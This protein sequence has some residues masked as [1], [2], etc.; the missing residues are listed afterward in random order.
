MKS[1]FG[2]NIQFSLFG[3]S[4]G[5][6]IGVHI[7]GLAPG[8]PLDL[9][10]LR[11][12]LD[13]RRP[14]GKI[15]TR[16]READEFEIVSGFFNGYTTG[17]PLCILIRNQSQHSRDYDAVKYT[18]RPSH[19]DFTAFEK[20][21]GF[22]DYRGGGHFSGRITAPIV[23]AGAICLQILRRKGI[24]IA[25]HIAHCR[26]VADEPFAGTEQELQ[27]QAEVLQG[28]Y[29][30]VLCDRAGQDMVREIE[31]AQEQ[32]DSVGGVLET[33]VLGMPAGIGEPF[34]GSVESVLA[35]LLFSI[36]AVKGVEFGLGFGFAQLYGSQANDPFV[37]REN[38]VRTKTNHNGGINGGISNGMPIVLRTVVK[39]TP[40][41]YQPQQT[42]DLQKMQEVQLRIHG[43]H[44][45]AVIHRAA[46]V[47]DSMAAIGLVDLFVE[48]YGYLWTAP[49]WKG[50]E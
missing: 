18:L 15:S 12:Q 49:S 25:T 46:V 9:D 13:R 50:G 43:R 14:Q 20:Y 1:T 16:R 26:G 33:V 23:V 8:I 4:H 28:R 41:I 27:R 39:P 42:V 38:C 21:F 47:T 30:P 5:S 17:T 7:N 37:V 29:F 3:E 32:G 44:D 6:A 31:Q 35:Q 22:Q 34:F 10:W 24:E 19:A 40:S 48:R 11:G 45:P 36:P 2:Q